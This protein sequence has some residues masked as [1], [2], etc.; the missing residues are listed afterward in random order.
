VLRGAER[1][2]HVAIAQHGDE[3]YRDVGEIRIGLEGTKYRPAIDLGHDHVENDGVGPALAGEPEPFP[4]VGG[5]EDPYI[6]LHEKKLSNLQAM[7]PVLEAVVQSAKPLLI[8]AEDVEGEALAMVVNKLR[9]GLKVAAVKAPG[10]G[11]RRRA[12]VEDMAVLTGGQVISEDLGIKLE[13]VNFPMLGRTKTVTVAKEDTH[14]CRRRWQEEG[15]RGPDQPDQG[16]DRGD[17]L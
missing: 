8:V 11:D 1:K 13:N 12:M 15:H 5:N 9:G 17:H 16:P 10:L 7:L 2:R 14:H 6:L 3:D 4:S